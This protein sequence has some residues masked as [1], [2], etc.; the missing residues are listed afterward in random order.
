MDAPLKLA[1]SD[2]ARW[3]YVAEQLAETAKT[4][5]RVNARL[6]VTESRLDDMTRHDEIEQTVAA[7]GSISLMPRTLGALLNRVYSDW[8][9][10]GLIVLA[11]YSVWSTFVGPH[12]G[13]V[14]H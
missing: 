13:I 1:T 4:L 2:E 3:A 7:V 9:T 10:V 5:E 12:V 8:R 6:E 14:L 11:L